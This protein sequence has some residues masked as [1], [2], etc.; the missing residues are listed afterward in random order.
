MYYVG[1]QGP[2]ILKIPGDFY[3]PER[4]RESESEREKEKEKESEREKKRKTER[5][6]KSVF[7]YI[8]KPAGPK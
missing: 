6:N 8:S 5:E 2:L 7:D 3:V 4:E 1:R